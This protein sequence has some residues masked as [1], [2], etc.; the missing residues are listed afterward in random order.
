MH[1][2]TV[3]S[4]NS[5]PLMIM[6]GVFVLI[7]L[8]M[9]AIM[10]SGSGGGVDNSPIFLTQLAM[11][12]TQMSMNLT[13]TALANGGPLPITPTWTPS[14]F[15]PPPGPTTVTP[16]NPPPPDPTTVTPFNPPPPGPGAINFFD[17]FDNGFSPLWQVTGEWIFTNGQPVFTGRPRCDGRL[18]TGAVNWDN[19]AIEVDKLN[20]NWSLLF[21]Y[22]DEQNYFY[23]N[24]NYIYEI[25]NGNK[26][27]VN[28]SS[29]NSSLF[30]KKIR[31]EIHGNRLALF[32]INSY[33]DV[34]Q[35][36]Y[37]QLARPMN[38]Q[39]GFSTCYTYGAVLDT[40]RVYS[41]P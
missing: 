35:V 18:L 19:Y 29:R 36:Y 6:G 28:T 40:F 39:V 41:I 37:L 31:L 24:F 13:M 27:E 15:P 8:G 2:R 20:S 9:A 34:S 14:A 25:Y 26:T 21:G 1:H 3:N 30:D 32:S 11:Q 22:K 5:F 33:G 4:Q 16:F 17:N 12:Q 10:T 7:F 23:I 38:G